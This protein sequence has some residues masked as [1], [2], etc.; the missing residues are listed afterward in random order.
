MKTALIV[1]MARSGVASAKLLYR[2]GY[3][4]IV[5]DM[6]SMI[7]GLSEALSGIEYENLLH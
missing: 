5:N 3:K 7:P 4:V 6:K 1:G 2:N